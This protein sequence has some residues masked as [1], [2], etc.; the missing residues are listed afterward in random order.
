MTE[1][2]DSEL[3][4]FMH[5]SMPFMATLGAEAVVATKE[6]VQTRL[7]WDATRTTAGDLMHGGALMALADGTG[8]WC[9][10]MHLPEGAGTAT[11]ESKTN[12]FRPLTEGWVDAIAQV[13]HAGSRFIVIDTELRDSKDR[14]VARVTQTQAILK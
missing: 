5:E 3:T 10:A 6:R 13:I 4:S 7:A 1:V 8:G 9:A 12:F 14:L 11:L 2:L